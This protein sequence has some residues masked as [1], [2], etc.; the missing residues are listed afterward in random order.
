FVNVFMGRLNSFVIDSR[1]GDGEHVGEK[2]TLASQRAILK[3]RARNREGSRQIGASMRTAEQLYDLAG[4]DVFTMP[5]AVAA[6]FH[7][8][9]TEQ[10]RKLSSQVER[11][12]E[13]HLNS[14]VDRRALGIDQLWEIPEEVIA[15]ADALEG[16]D[17]RGWSGEQ[18]AEA[19]RRHGAG[20]LFPK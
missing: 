14:G 9:M 10:P 3:L 2:T 17:V 6:E 7:R 13:I 16:M 5:T 15:F 1:L 8:Q 20:S 18:F 11:D 19:G 4:L 12:F